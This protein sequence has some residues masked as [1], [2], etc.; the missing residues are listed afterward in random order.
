[1]R[2][3]NVYARY[4]V[5]LVGAQAQ[6]RSFSFIKTFPFLSS[7]VAD[8]FSLPAVS[9]VKK[10][11]PEREM[12]DSGKRLPMFWNLLESGSWVCSE[13]YE[14]RPCFISQNPPFYCKFI[15]FLPSSEFTARPHNSRN[16]LIF[17]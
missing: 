5:A 6:Q 17:S 4:T 12:P 14:S 15:K 16:S 10:D 8:L 13:T 3:S 11:M 7:R 2:S 9:D 1:M